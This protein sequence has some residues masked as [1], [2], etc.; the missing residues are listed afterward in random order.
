M[1]D[2]L[3]FFIGIFFIIWDFFTVPELKLGIKLRNYVT[4]PLLI[5]VIFSMIVE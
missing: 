1:Y 2:F 3:I 4:I 5:Y